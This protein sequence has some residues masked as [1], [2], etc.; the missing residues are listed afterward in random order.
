MENI[1]TR[2]GIG[3]DIHRLIPGKKLILGG[4]TIPHDSGLLGHSDA[5]VLFHATCDALLG[6]A[7]LG[8]IGRYFPDSDPAY[9]D[10]NSALFLKETL[11]MIERKGLLIRNIDTTIY[12]ETPRIAPYAE[13]MEENLA[14]TLEMDKNNVN[15]K[16]T[17]WEGLGP[18]GRKEAIAAQ[19]IA[20]LY[21]TK[22]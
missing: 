20:C 18:I 17:T 22:T 1:I 21:Q 12:T 7:A 19:C 2:V 13:T 6:A 16:A 8:D 5:D 14:R 11:R 10:A 4:I 15:V 9:K 3:Y